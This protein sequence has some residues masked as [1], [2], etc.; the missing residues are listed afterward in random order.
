MQEAACGNALTIIKGAAFADYIEARIGK[1]D[2]MGEKAHVVE[3]AAND[4]TG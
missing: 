4:A 1:D 2:L 3:S